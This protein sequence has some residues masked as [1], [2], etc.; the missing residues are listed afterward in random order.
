MKIFIA[1]NK[2]C[3]FEYNYDL[4][5]NK[6]EYY[7]IDRPEE[8]DVI[9]FPNTC[10]GT[11]GSIRDTINYINGI[12][13]RKKPSAKTYITGCITKFINNVDNHYDV[14]TR[15]YISRIK[16]YLE[17]NI[18]FIVLDG[19]INK[20]I[21]LI[22]QN[23]NGFSSEPLVGFS[24]AEK[25]G[26]SIIANLHI[27]KGCL[28]RCTFCETNYQNFKL[29]SADINYVK[30][31]IDQIDENHELSQI[32]LTAS[33]VTQY[34]LDLYGRY[35]LPEV[36]NYMEAKNNVK[37][38]GLVGFAFKD[39]IKQYL[40]EQL[41]TGGKPIIIFG[42][43]ESGSDR[44]LS[45]M[46]KGYSAK[47][48]KTFIEKIR[49]E[50]LIFLNANIIAGFPTE[51]MDDVMMTLDLLSAIDVLSVNLCTYSDSPLIPSHQ[52]PQLPKSTVLTHA[53]T[54]GKELALRN[55]RVNKRY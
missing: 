45:M 54:Y 7:V 52:L 4:L 42:G 38:I 2:T 6:L 26:K 40:D 48:I 22:F 3:G 23:N 1:Y 13:Q 35:M 37:A 12:L 34:G 36:I 51:T 43:L 20:L 53:E 11:F 18:D 17:E 24:Q 39:A 49:R 15:R 29:Q 32:Y 25:Y 16:E 41:K 14:E 28:N 33:N 47:E 44:I 50:R 21:Q 19:E 55:I 8:A 31:E 10:T 5:Y 46:K 27:A 30:G 9:I